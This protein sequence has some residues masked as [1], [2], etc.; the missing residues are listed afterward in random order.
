MKKFWKIVSCVDTIKSSLLYFVFKQFIQTSPILYVEK[1]PRR[2]KIIS[3]P[4]RYTLLIGIITL[5]V[6][7]LGIWNHNYDYHE[8]S[9]YK[10]FFNII[11]RIWSTTGYLIYIN[12]FFLNI[13]HSERWIYILVLQIKYLCTYVYCI[14]N[15]WTA[16]VK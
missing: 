6:I 8:H 10:V 13:L 3:I 11:S 15:F 5:L 16:R 9:K 7:H 1:T 2:P 4:M 12:N 14:Y